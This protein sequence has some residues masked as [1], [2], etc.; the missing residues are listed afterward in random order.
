MRSRD[1]RRPGWRAA[2]IA[3]S[4]SA[5]LALLA[6]LLSTLVYSPLP[7]P[8]VI[9]VQLTPAP[10][11]APDERA[12]TPVEPAPAAPPA[13]APSP[14]VFRISPTRA[15]TPS[16]IL[17]APAASPRPTPATPGPVPTPADAET[18]QVREALRLSVGCDTADLLGLTRRE[19]DLCNEARAARA[20]R[21]EPVPQS[22]TERRRADWRAAGREDTT[23]GSRIGLL[24]PPKRSS[25]LLEDPIM[26]GVTVPFGKPPKAIT[27]IAP[28]TLRG[29]DDAL[30]P[31]PRAGE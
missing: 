8:P 18:L 31:K 13:R 12:E 30:R 11:P 10:R 26:V 4:L 17:A 9:Q 5:H 2:V 27:P 29:D 25:P 7:A 15:T 22:D 21:Y 6:A 24:P 3:L 28:S 20:A 1:R 19:R 14:P 23:A 16:S